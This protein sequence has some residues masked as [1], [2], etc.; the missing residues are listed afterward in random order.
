MRCG[1][2]EIRRGG[3]RRGGMW[4]GEMWGRL[5]GAVHSVAGVAQA[6]DDVAFFVEVVVEG[7]G[8]DGDVGVCVAEFL[9]AFWSGDEADHSEVCCSGVFEHGDGGGG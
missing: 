3:D 6:W 2:C 1:S 7:G 8:V 4:G 9:D 5:D